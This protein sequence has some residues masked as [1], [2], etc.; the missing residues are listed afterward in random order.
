M[1]RREGGRGYHQYRERDN[2]CSQRAASLRRNITR[3]YRHQTRVYRAKPPKHDILRI[4]RYMMVTIRLIDACAAR[5]SAHAARAPARK[6]L[7]ASVRAQKRD[8]FDAA[9]SAMRTAFTSRRRAEKCAASASP[10]NVVTSRHHHHH[11]RHATPNTS[12]ATP[13]TQRRAA[14]APLPGR[15]RR[16]CTQNIDYHHHSIAN[17]AAMVAVQTV[18]QRKQ[19]LSSILSLLIENV[20]SRYF[21]RQRSAPHTLIITD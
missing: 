3:H 8:A 20:T 18:A 2:S 17:N 16:R 1:R 7:P 21:P 6:C 9:R 5:N 14:R 10:V 11:H 4:E 19:R 12:H 15:R 13:R